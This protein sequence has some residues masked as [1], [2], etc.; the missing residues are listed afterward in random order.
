M[1]FLTSHSPRKSALGLALLAP[2]LGLHGQDWTLI[3]KF[4]NGTSQKTWITTSTPAVD[5]S[6]NQ[7][8]IKLQEGTNTT[9]SHRV[10][11]PRNPRSPNTFTI[12]FDFYLPTPPVEGLEHQVGFGVGSDAQVQEGSWATTGVRNR[13]QTIGPAPQDLG[14]AYNWGV[15]GEPGYGTAQ[16]DA[17]GDTEFGVFYNI[18]LVY[19]T[20]EPDKGVTIY[21]KKATESMDALTS[22]FFAFDDDNGNSSDDWSN[23][24][25]FAIGQGAQSTP[26]E[27]FLNS[28]V[29]GGVFDNFYY[30]DGELLTLTPTSIQA[31]WVEVDTFDNGAPEATWMVDPEITIAVENGSLV[32]TGTTADAALYTELPY[33]SARTSNTLTFDLLLPGG[34]SNNIAFA[35]VGD[36]QIAGTGSNRFGGADRFVTYPPGASPQ[37]LVN[38]G[39]WTTDL[40][41]GTVA[42]QWYHV[43]LVYDGSAGKVDVYSVPVADPVESVTLPSEPS[44]SFEFELAYEDLGTFILGTAFQGNGSGL[45]IDNIYQAQGTLIELSPTAGVFDGGS[46]EPVSLWK[47]LPELAGGFKDAGIGLIQDAHYPFVFHVPTKGYIYIADEYSSLETIW[48]YTYGDGFWFWTADDIGGWH[49]NIEDSGYGNSG[50]AAW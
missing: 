23:V 29:L 20:D 33:G 41:G 15:Q 14:N 28:D 49:F 13:F 9:A 43:W 21:S 37:T 5:Y 48:G 45:K 46:T 8:E 35:V 25:W 2:V 42:D 4:D 38:F 26:P 39:Q 44:G 1:K 34:T 36:T 7:L 12:A 40:L 16:P 32:V 11:L 22:E 30:S 47:D 6:N 18:W 3:D 27:G 24:L 19:K 31:G 17:L 50:W 10:Q